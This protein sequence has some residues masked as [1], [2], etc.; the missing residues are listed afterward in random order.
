[1]YVKDWMSPNPIVVSPETPIM[2]AQKIMREHRIRRLPV[3]QKGKLVGIVTYR[4]L[5]EAS[6]SDATTLSIHELN[7]LLS[8]LTV[9]DVMAKDVVTVSPNDTAEHAVLLGVEKGVG[10]LPVVHKGKLVGIATEA[11]IV[12]FYMAMLGARE[13]LVRITLQDVDVKHGTL[14]EI[15]DVVEEA[16]GVPIS[17]F[18]I[19]QKASDMRMVMIRA[20]GSQRKIERALRNKGYTIHR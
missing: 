4:D 8:K 15:A 6:P 1:M 13:E 18:S 19:P 2:E 11:D 10:A 7:Y 5:I 9:K 20:K 12:R 17:I 16:G 3:V 14:K